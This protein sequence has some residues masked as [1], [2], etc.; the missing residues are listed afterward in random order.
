MWVRGWIL[1]FLFSALVL[2][3]DGTRKLR[4]REVSTLLFLHGKSTTTR[5]TASGPQMIQTA[6]P[7]VLMNFISCKNVGVDGADVTWSCRLSDELHVRLDEFD[8]QCEG[9]DRPYDEFI[10]VG[11]CH[12]EY[13]LKWKEPV[14]SSASTAPDGPNYGLLK[15]AALL[16]VVAVLLFLCGM[17]RRPPRRIPEQAR[18]RTPACPHSFPG[19]DRVCFCIREDD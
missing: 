13:T 8:I 5:Y 2:A 16:A 10:L 4:L 15:F 7:H 9:Y 17:C 6:G 18:G 19:T 1:V 11:S 12:I 3:S 14:V